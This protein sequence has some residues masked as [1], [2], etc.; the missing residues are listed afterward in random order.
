MLCWKFLKVFET[1]NSAGKCLMRSH[2]ISVVCLFPV[3]LQ[4]NQT[5]FTAKG[6]APCWPLNEKSFR[7]FVLCL[8]FNYAHHLY[9]IY[10]WNQRLQSGS[11]CFDRHWPSCRM[12]RS[13]AWT[14]GLNYPPAPSS[15]GSSPFGAP[16]PGGPAGRRKPRCWPS[17]HS[18]A[19]P[20]GTHTHKRMIKSWRQVW[21]HHTGSN[22]LKLNRRSVWKYEWWV[23]LLPRL[24]RAGR[25]C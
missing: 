19:P 22:Y 2:I 6:V 21:W 3:V 13:Q 25:S 9:A 4:H 17:S 16:P 12:S 23:T 8:D 20:A 5:S 7:H 15:G 24:L 1:I 14:G 11:K 18:A 10:G